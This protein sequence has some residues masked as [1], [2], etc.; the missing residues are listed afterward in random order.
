[1][2]LADRTATRLLR[3]PPP[4][5]DYTVRHD[6]RVPMRDGVQLLADH[7]APTTSKPAGTI[8]IRGPYG[9]RG[10]SALLTGRIYAARGYHVLMQS[11]RGTFGSGGEFNPGRHEIDDG[12]DTVAWLREQPWFASRFATLGASYLGFTQWALLH[13]PPPELKAA[14]IMVGPHDLSEAVWGTGSFALNDFLGWSDTVAHQEDGG[15]RTLVSMATARW[16]VGPAMHDL[17]LGDAGRALLGEQAQWYQDWVANPDQSAEYWLPVRL[18]RALEN[19][20]VP[21]LLI[22]GWQDVFLNQTL[23]QYRQLQQ[24]GVDVALTVGPWTH[25][26]VGLNAAGQTTRESLDWLDHQLAGQPSTRSTPVRIFVTGAGKWCEFDAWPPPAEEKTLYLQPN[27]KLGDRPPPTAQPSQF[28]YDPADPT[29]TIGGRLL[30]LS[31]GYRNDTK[32]AQRHDVLAFT[33]APLAHDLDVIGYPRVELAH[34]TDIPHAD[35]FVRLS[36]VDGKGRSRNVSDGYVRLGQD[37]TERLHIELD[38]IA[39]RFRAGHRIRLLVA[40]GSH[41]RFSRNLGTDDP[42]HTGHQMV[43]ST[44]TIAHGSGGVSSV[45]LPIHE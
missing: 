43:R 3:L 18:H 36:E 34:T 37:R 11:A 39:H 10:M 32:L 24:R 29:P 31:A 20:T 17:P 26:Q 5:T 44:H 33:G 42:P 16:R 19:A 4:T 45:L 30:S 13:D 40:G 12:A 25:G 6:I 14:V 9:R 41:P 15:W 28:V 8:L 22:T 2:R 7:Y 1:M 38:G 35:V 27:S 23:D 21:I